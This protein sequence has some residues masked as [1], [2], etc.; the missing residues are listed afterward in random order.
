MGGTYYDILGVSPLADVQEIKLA[1]RHLAK[2]YHPDRQRNDSETDEMFKLITH[3]YNVLSNREKRLQYD[4]QLYS[5]IQISNQPTSSG[6]RPGNLRRPT[7]WKRPTRYVYTAQTKITGAFF[8][9]FLALLSISLPVG[10]EVYSVEKHFE[11]GVILAREGRYKEAVDDLDFAVNDIGLRTL[12]AATMISRLSFYYLR[13]YQKTIN[14]TQIAIKNSESNELN[15]EMHYLRASALAKFK[16]A[17]LAKE[18][19]LK[20]LSFAPSFDSAI[21]GLA[22]LEL[23]QLHNFEEADKWYAELYSINPLFPKP[24]YSLALMHFQL[25]EYEDAMRFITSY[26][27]DSPEDGQALYLGGVISFRVKNPEQGCSFLRR[28]KDKGY[29]VD[30]PIIAKYC[31]LD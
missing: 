11:K 4:Y 17:D 7:R 31:G 14:Y 8:V 22:E 21:F 2:K 28:A 15:A 20:S 24:N 19:Y 1:Y 9:L 6:T 10:L 23:H 5:Q 16:R 30:N 18:D 3:A 12:E 29:R 27:K 13:D 26:L 25:E